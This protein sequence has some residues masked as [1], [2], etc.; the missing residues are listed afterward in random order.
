MSK[1]DQKTAEKQRKSRRTFLALG[2]GACAAGLAAYFG[3][4]RSDDE[5]S[6]K[7]LSMKEFLN[8]KMLKKQGSLFVHPAFRKQPPDAYAG[9]AFDAV[10]PTLLRECGNLEGIRPWMQTRCYA[11][12][13][14][15][16]VVADFD[17]RIHA[18]AD[19]Y[20]ADLGLPA[21]V[22]TIRRLTPE[23]PIERKEGVLDVLLVAK[24]TKSYAFEKDG[25][26]LPY[27][28]SIP[29]NVSVGEV[30]TSVELDATGDKVKIQLSRGPALVSLTSTNQPNEDTVRVVSITLSEILHYHTLAYLKQHMEHELS[31]YL[32]PTG[33]P[34]DKLQPTVEKWLGIEEG[35]V[36]AAT[37]KWTKDR[38]LPRERDV[39]ANMESI[40]KGHSDPQYH[41]LQGL[42]RRDIVP[43]ELVR[44]Y[45]DEPE[46]LL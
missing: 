30:P 4:R 19:Q 20:F 13:V 17:R 12:A 35:V 32:V 44:L 34:S 28:A 18:I 33:L 7:D 41:R 27:E 11:L 15:D 5:R 37:F 38:W 16:E 14:P 24:V 43:R 29:H 3:L 21:P 2:L 10:R 6:M 39:T 22:M 25:R 26:L 42:Y 23:T 9:V 45:R 31:S 8:Q 40:V 46:K 1:R 36:H